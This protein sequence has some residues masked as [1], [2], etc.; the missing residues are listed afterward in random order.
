MAII[1]YSGKKAV[2]IPPNSNITLPGYMDK[3][4]P[5]HTTAAM[6]SIT[7]GSIVPSDLDISPSLI[8]YRYQQCKEIRVNISNVTTRT[9]NIPPHALICELQ[10]VTIQNTQSADDKEF[11]QPLLE[12]IK[13][14]ISNLTHEEYEIGKKLITD[15]DTIF[16]KDE[17]DDGHTTLLKHRIDLHDEHPFKQIYRRIPPSMYEEVKNHLHLLLRTGIIRKSH[18][19]YSS[20]LV[21]VKKKDNSLRICVDYRQLNQKT[22]KDAYVLPRIEEILDCLAGNRYFSVIDMKSGFHQVEILEEHKERTAFTVGPLGLYEY[23]M[24]PFLLE[25]TND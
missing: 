2:T 15:Y 12:Q 20:N 18:S 7:E 24:M 3:Q 23:N 16:S 25:H 9:V 5:Y 4:L 14:D 6:V 13:F 8:E 21:L 22:K 10:P 17:T 19:P 11:S 1:K